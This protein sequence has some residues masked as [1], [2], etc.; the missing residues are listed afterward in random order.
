[1]AKMINLDALSD[2]MVRRILADMLAVDADNEPE[3][4]VNRANAMRVGRALSDDTEEDTEAT[5]ARR[6]RRTRR[7]VT[8]QRYRIQFRDV[9]TDVMTGETAEHYT[10]ML[11]ASKR[12]DGW[13]TEADIIAARGRKDGSALKAAESCIHWLKSHDKRGQP[14]NVEDNGGKRAIVGTER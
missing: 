2:D 9:D 5:P 7:T 1:M 3:S 4:R 11:K 6:R 12:G 10:A 14:L 13:L 8:P